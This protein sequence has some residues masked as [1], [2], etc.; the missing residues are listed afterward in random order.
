[1]E[2]YKAWFHYWRD[3]FNDACCKFNQ[4]F[5]IK[6]KSL[7]NFIHIL[8][9]RPSL[10]SAQAIMDD[11]CNWSGRLGSLY[12]HRSNRVGDCLVEFCTLE[13]ALNWWKISHNRE[14]QILCVI[15]ISPWIDSSETHVVQCR[16]PSVGIYI[17]ESCGTHTPFT[18]EALLC[19]VGAEC[20][21]AITTKSTGFLLHNTNKNM[22]TKSLP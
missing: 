16:W 11:C 10:Y 9:I 2:A 7:R 4:N 21:E 6:N 18:C 12:R 13:R 8:E 15:R 14:S 19:S 22:M 3:H 1:M 5:L 17:V 20:L